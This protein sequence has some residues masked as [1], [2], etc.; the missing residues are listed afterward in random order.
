MN[1]DLNVCSTDKYF[2]MTIDELLKSDDNGRTVEEIK[3]SK[4]GVVSYFDNEEEYTKE[5]KSFEKWLDKYN[6]K[7]ILLL[8]TINGRIAA[9][10]RLKSILNM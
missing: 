9:V 8:K 4:L 2:H 6:Y 7:L 10:Y 1:N 5:E 3:L